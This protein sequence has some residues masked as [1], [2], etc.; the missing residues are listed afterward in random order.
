M[1][2][3]SKTAFVYLGFRPAFLMMKVLDIDTN[4][5]QYY[6]WT[7]LDNARSPYNYTNP[8]LYANMSK[9]ENQRGGSTDA[10]GPSDTLDFLSNGFKVRMTNDY[11]ELGGGVNQRYIYMAFAEQPGAFS[12]AR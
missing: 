11:G 4:Y 2:T 6:P 3:G 8:P 1:F 12:N 10:Y 7:M 5:P 9:V